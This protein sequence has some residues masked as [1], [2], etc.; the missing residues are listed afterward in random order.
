[1]ISNLKPEDEQKLS[2]ELCVGEDQ[3][4]WKN[5]LGDGNTELV[6]ETDRNPVCLNHKIQGERRGRSSEEWE[7]ERVT[8]A[9]ET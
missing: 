9:K 1:M 2:G 3:T 5:A 8:Y 4:A 7:A 6:R